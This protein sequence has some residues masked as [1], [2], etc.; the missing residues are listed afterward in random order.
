ME[1]TRHSSCTLCS[2][3]PFFKVSN[4]GALIPKG[5]H[6]PAVSRPK[7]SGLS[8][9]CRSD[10]HSDMTGTLQRRMSGCRRAERSDPP[11]PR[12][13]PHL[14]RTRAPRAASQSD[15]FSTRAEPRSHAEYASASTPAPAPGR[16]CH[17]A[18]KIPAFLLNPPNVCQ[19]CRRAHMRSVDWSLLPDW[20]HRTNP[21]SSTLG[22]RAPP[23]GLLQG[24][25]PGMAAAPA[26]A[27]W[28]SAT[29]GACCAD[30]SP[31]RW[32]PRS[33]ARWASSSPHPAAFHSRAC[34]PALPAAHS[35][36]PP[37]KPSQTPPHDRLIG[38]MTSRQ[39]QLAAAPA[40]ESLLRSH[41][42]VLA[43]GGSGAAV[44]LA[45]D[46]HGHRPCAL[47]TQK[48]D[49][50]EPVRHIPIAREH[51]DSSSSRVL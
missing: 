51:W 11:D 20:K 2:E 31:V 33:D 28:H 50:Q 32:S 17:Y 47:R 16:H 27:D 40:V 42:Q 14:A 21:G 3:E 9:L 48:R 34:A 24:P 13:E 4:V 39:A 23:L 45:L 29:A 35:S 15:S 6:S 19:G 7:L 30:E 25:P 10:A 49:G 36:R 46:L 38:D 5:A 26:A 37:R 43:L 12:R 44:Q 18:P 1:S 8:L 41:L 22:G